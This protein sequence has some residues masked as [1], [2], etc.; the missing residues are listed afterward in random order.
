MVT[1]VKHDL[2]FI[3]KQ[4]KIAEAHAAGGDLAELVG[5]AGGFDPNAP[6]TPTQAALLPYGLRTVDGSYNNLIP[7]REMWGASDQEFPGIFDPNYL[8][9]ADGDSLAFGPGITYTNNDY[10]NAGPGSGTSPGPGSGTVIDADPRII[11][12]LIVDQTLANPAAIM[13][14]LQHAGVPGAELM[15]ALGEVRTAYESNKGAI[16]AATDATAAVAVAQTNL[17]IATTNLQ[18]AVP[19]FPTALAAYNAANDALELAQEASATATA[20]ATAAIAALNTVLGTH[21][22]EMDGN[23]ILL[24]NVAPDE[25]LSSPFNGWMTIF[26][27]FFDHGLDLVAKGGN[28]N[29]YVPLQPD[30]PLYVEGSH[31][32]FMVLSRVTVDAGPDG[33]LG[34]ADDVAAPK[35]LTTPWV[36]QNQTYSSTASK[37][38]FMREY[39]ATPDGPR[40]TGHLLEGDAG[41]LATWADV[42]AQAREVLGINLTDAHV[43]KIPLIA[44]DP[45]GNFIPGPNGYPQLVVG[46]GPDG[47]LGTS[48]DILLEGDPTANG[49]L[50]VD[51]PAST[52]LTGHAFLDDIAHNA[53]P[54]GVFDHDNNPVTPMVPIGPD[55]DNVAGNPIATDSRGNLVAYDNELL[56]AHYIAGDGRAN[57]NIALT[58][59]HHVFHS[60]HNRV[61]EHT[62][63]VVLQSG[64]LDFINEWLLIDVTSVPTTQAEIDAL[65]WNGERLFQAARFVNE[66]EYQHLVF[67]EFGRMMQPDIDAFVFEPSV[68]INP[69]IA[70]EFAHVVYRFGHSMLREDIARISLDE[71]GNPVQDDISLFEGF[72]N[73]IAFAS[74]GDADVAAGAIIRGMSRQVGNEIDEFVTDVLRNQLLGIP[75]DLAT[76]NLARGRDV[77]TPP[78]NAARAKFYEATHDTQLKPYVSWAD[79]A[80][81]LKNPA[82]IINFIAAYGTHETITSA[83]TVEE[84]R[85]AA[86]LLVLGGAGEPADRLDFLNS[87]GAWAN[88]ESGLNTV[89]FWIGGLAEKKMAFGGMLGSTFSFV[90][91][92]TMENLQDADRFYYL[93]RTQ[94]LNLL[95][96]LENNTFAELV[97]RNTDLGDPGS[98]AL[99]GNLFSAFEMP[100]LEMDPSKQLGADPVHDDPMLQ[101]VSRLVER[102]DAAGNLIAPTDTT[103]VAAY[104]RVNSNE[105]FT[106]GGTENDDTIVSGGGDD[107]V[108]G[109]GGDD[110]IEAGYGVDK[111]FGGEGDD[112]ITNSGTD[113]GETDFLHGNEGNDVIHGGSG[114]ALIFGN[115]G[116]DFLVTG[117]DGKEVFG[118]T[119]NDFIL[120]GEGGDLLLGN[121]G[122]DWLEGGPRFDTL[123]GENSELMFNSSIIG[124]DVLLGG[125]GDTDYD[126]ESGDDIM[127]QAV[128]IQRN[129]GM[130]G[131]DWAIHKGDDV[132]ANSDLG[133]PL[134]DNQEAFILRDRFDL[135][136]GLSGWKHN[137]I[138]TGREE[139]VNTRAEA[140]G[141]AAI[142][143]PDSALDSYSNALLEKNLSLVNGLDT[144]VAHIA[145]TTQ[146]GNDGVTEVV[147]M[148]TADAS[149]ILLGGGGNDRIQGK[150]GNDV[151]DGDR[152]LNVRIS[153]RDANGNEIATADSLTGKLYQT[154]AALAAL[155]AAGLFNPNNVANFQ[156]MTLQQ[157]LFNRT[158]N[159]GQLN[160]V[161]ELLDGDPAN[162]N[163]DTAVYRDVR[164]NYSFSTNTVDDS[165][166]VDHTGFVEPQQDDD[167]EEDETLPRLRSDGRDTLRNIE[168]L[169]F[170]DGALNIIEG[171]AAGETLNGTENDDLINGKAGDDIL[172]GLGGNDILLGGG[173]NDTLNGGAGDDVLV[174]GAG[175][176]T[177]NG[178]LD[179]DT[180]S[181][182]AADGTDTINETGGDDRIEITAGALTDLAFSETTFGAGN[183]NLVVQFNGQQITVAD[184]FENNVEAVESINLDGATYE[185]YAFDGD[186]A[187]STDDNGTRSAQAGVNTL[188]AGTTGGDDLAGN[189]G[190]DLLFGHSGNDDLDGGDGDDLLVGGTGDD[191][192][193]GGL[194]SDTMAGGSGNDTYEVD[195]E[196]DLVVEALGGGADEVETSLAA[197]TLTANVEDLTYTGAGNF[198]GTGNELANRM[199]GGAGIDTL[200]GLGGNDTYVVTAGD[201]IVEAAGAGTDTV[202]AAASYTLGENLENLTLAGNGDTDGTGNILANVIIG[203]SGDNQL[204][205]GGGNDTLNGG[206]G[207]DLLDG[208]TGDDILNAGSGDNVIVGGAGNDTINLTTTPGTDDI[209]RYD[210]NGFGD[211]VINGFD[212]TATGGQDRIDLSALGITAANLASRVIESTVSGDT[213]LTIRDASLNTIGT[214]RVDNVSNA[215]IDAGDFI[216]AGSG[217]STGGA[218][219]GNN[220]LNGT[221]GD[222]VIDALGGNDTVNGNGGNDTITG[223]TGNDAINGGSGDDIIIWNANSVG[224]TDGRDEINGGTEGLAGDTFIINGNG[225]SETYRI[226]TR[227]AWDALPGNIGNNLDNATEIV[228]TRNGT[229]FNSII[230]ELTEIE[231]IR[232]NGFDPSVTG[233]SGGDSF[234]IIGD[235]SGTHLRL[236]TITIDGD[237]GDDTVDISSLGSAHRIVFRSNGGNDTIVGA[238][239]AQDV[240]ELPPGV[241]VGDYTGTTDE[242]GVT[243]LT[244][245]THSISFVADGMPQVVDDAGNRYEHDNDDDDDNHHGHD[246][247]CDGDGSNGPSGPG[248]DDEEDEDEDD[249]NAPAPVA[250]RTLLGTASA[251]G[252]LGGA[253]A[254]TVLAGGGDDLLAGEEGD[255][256]LRGEA[257]DDLLTAGSGNDVASGGLGNDEIHGGTGNDMIFGDGGADR[258]YGDDGDDVVE[259]GA[260]NDR[261][262]TG[263][264]NDTVLAT[265]GDGSDTYWGGEGSDTLDYAAASANLT[266]DMGNG[267]MERGQVSGSDTGTDTVYGFENFVGGSGHDVITASL[268]VNIIDG[269]LGEDVFRFTSA[270]AANGDKIYGFQPGDKI[271]FSLL[272]ADT[273]VA[274]IQSFSL[275][276][277]ALTAVGEIAVTHENRDG[278]DLT[279]IRGNVNDN[280]DADFEMAIAG[281]HHLKV[282]DFNGVS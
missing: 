109:K 78:L 126:G 19:D 280:P 66:M 184:H 131:F 140:T 268:A 101:A 206:T 256:V 31:T 29:V 272:D 270:A 183:D 191:D 176:D 212:A 230:A 250:G 188:L 115:Q 153:V 229:D 197:Y 150:A 186:Y 151:I 8:N 62:K 218:T 225:S 28:G 82:S 17:A 217:S 129:N 50:G 128:G 221:N 189:T 147:V 36:D 13:A 155:D 110:T 25:G 152:W 216:L 257:G 102:R 177:L 6:G 100:T 220:T 265:I 124:H 192:L 104:I 209:I 86:T 193:I 242:E 54:G 3:L 276:S 277:G 219:N 248:N 149:D 137:D 171:T 112:I 84:K 273:G 144:L 224:P 145:R 77:G 215:A 121:E 97:M 22:I 238:L 55:A 164:E 245:G 162:G 254:D 266:V 130:A 117:P 132:A 88:V 67:E 194:G 196:D 1:V 244:D 95:N 71:N 182:G 5:E 202:I 263:T 226:Y 69:N 195:D 199:Q 198:A 93:S 118:G 89:D 178:G 123:A 237:E 103:T 278:E 157:A 207:S 111:V 141:T 16:T 200:T 165:L 90:F 7:G 87:T 37:Q 203:N 156:G 231:E 260:G 170:T 185:G 11:S 51:I 159:P 136:E 187:L 214:I 57:E 253:A 61:V 43:G 201:V 85:D 158:L 269:G 240:I 72:L 282:N 228:V 10:G 146:T 15:T 246:D 179:D 39:V 258:L 18:N 281:T 30:D 119:G 223:G 120:G 211:D 70:A 251:D 4:I 35:N 9:D 56:D 166:V 274:E 175:N 94:G 48:D 127:S 20:A 14:A 271:D 143:G 222:N 172:N 234:Q 279:I 2:D 169:Q 114:L 255:D 138:L 227:A 173:G 247:D 154:P 213:V 205:G 235:F 79:Y 96:E 241:N 275:V 133:I 243:T 98:T 33:R 80:L 239:R 41:G 233:A 64:D 208:G 68:D 76:I 42:K 180:Y 113:I 40:A 38:I 122:D 232:I 34:T 52:V 26:G 107:A 12:N 46:L 32:N 134:F 73:P 45:Y 105:H 116:N 249:G 125:S 60:E 259:G 21:G 139:P 92:M 65:V 264:G 252:L 262:W 91:E 163:V 167:V 160:I 181:F 106:I 267:F 44:S 236:N 24:P 75:L 204:F 168:A 135:V 23:T 83:G 81:N 142:P 63:D 210:A 27:Q 261:I 49:G 99:P 58:A 161:R 59:V 74:A 53:V 174:G 190:D 108:W 148:D 47:Q